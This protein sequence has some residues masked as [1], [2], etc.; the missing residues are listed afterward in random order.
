MFHAMVEELGAVALHANIAFQAFLT[1]L[2]CNMAF[3]AF[4][5]CFPNFV[6]SRV[7]AAV[8][9]AVLDIGYF[10]TSWALYID[11]YWVRFNDIF[12]QNFWVYTSMYVCVAHV[13]CVCRS[14]ETADWIA[15]FKVP[16]APPI[17]GAWKRVLVSIAYACGLFAVVAML[18]GGSVLA[19]LLEGGLCPPCDCSTVAP[20]SVAL[21][22]CIIQQHT[23]TG[24]QGGPYVMYSVDTIDLRD[25]RL[26]ALAP[27]A[28][29]SRDSKGQ[30]WHYLRPDEIHLERNRLTTVPAGAFEG[31]VVKRLFLQNNK[32]THLN[33]GSFRGVSFMSYWIYSELSDGMSELDLSQL[34]L[35]HNKLQTLPPKVFDFGENYSSGMYLDYSGKNVFSSE[36]DVLNLAHNEIS[37]LP[38]DTFA[39]HSELGILNF[40]GPD[41]SRF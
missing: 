27:R 19:S 29:Q 37:I 5:L 23:S 7:G 17:W 18:L 6:F 40:P 2:F 33:A 35:S 11:Y 21:E 26:T 16:A 32:L 38:A 9:D 25:K 36:L 30:T 28:F 22:R 4:V 1:V 15:L 10:I 39:G 14:L 41:I 3:P 31:V 8:V 20:G 12:Q 24:E 34:D 13:L